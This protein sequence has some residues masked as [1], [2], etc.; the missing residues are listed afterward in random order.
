MPVRPVLSTSRLSEVQA[1]LS[2][3]VRPCLSTEKDVGKERLFFIITFI[4]LFLFVCL[5]VEHGVLG[6]QIWG[7]PRI[8]FRLLGLHGRLLGP[9][10]HFSGP[11]AFTSSFQCLL[12]VLTV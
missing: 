11:M 8:E 6:R 2:Y 9:L 3:G 7:D 4:G 5:F 10:S 1:S 12:K